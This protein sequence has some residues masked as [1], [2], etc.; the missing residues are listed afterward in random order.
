MGE[1]C[2]QKALVFA[3]AFNP[4]TIAHIL[5]A[6]KAREYLHYDKVIFVPSK[7]KYIESVQEKDFAY[8]EEKRLT[9]LKEIAKDYPFRV[10]SDIELKKKEQPRTYFTL[11]ELSKEYSKIRLLFGSDKLAELEKGW[12]YVDEIGREF[13]FALLSR[14]GENSR[15]ILSSTPYLKERRGYFTLIPPSEEYQNV[16]SSLVRKR[17]KE[18]KDVSLYV[19]K[20]IRKELIEK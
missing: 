19:P 16:S 3:G 14:N 5:L 18:K 1:P 4:P 13:G 10:V 9:R 7:S 2:K 17:I 12:K 11:L 6:R 15:K 20:E 8:S